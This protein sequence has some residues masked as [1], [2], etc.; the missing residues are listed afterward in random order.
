M[1]KIYRR[2]LMSDLLSETQLYNLFP[3]DLFIL[4]IISYW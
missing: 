3:A 4:L 2:L 1:R